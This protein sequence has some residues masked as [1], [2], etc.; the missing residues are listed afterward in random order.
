MTVPSPPVR[1]RAMRSARSTASLPVQANMTWP[2]S[3]GNVASNR[4]E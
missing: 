4:S 1:K 3:A 2:I